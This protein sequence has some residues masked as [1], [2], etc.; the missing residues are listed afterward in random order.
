MDIKELRE[1]I[2]KYDREIAELLTKRME[3]AAK[4]GFIEMERL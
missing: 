2:D 3:T 4:I 1:D